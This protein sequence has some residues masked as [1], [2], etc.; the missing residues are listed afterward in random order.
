MNVPMSKVKGPLLDGRLE[1]DSFPSY[2]QNCQVHP[3]IFGALAASQKR[4]INH[5]NPFS[6]THHLALMIIR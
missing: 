3:L 1:E 4:K 2:S 6:A 5:P